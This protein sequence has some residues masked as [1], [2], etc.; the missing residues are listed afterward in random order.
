MYE[1]GFIFLKIAYNGRDWSVTMNRKIIAFLAFALILVVAPV[2][3]YFYFSPKSSD[4][5]NTLRLRNH[6]YGYDDFF[7]DLDSY[8]GEQL[9]FVSNSLIDNTY[10]DTNILG[11]L[12]LENADDNI[13][14]DI[15]HLDTAQD[16]DLT[17]T[18]LKNRLEIETTPAFVFANVKDSKV[19]VID[20]L[21]YYDD[22]PFTKSQLKDWLYENDLWLGPYLD[23]DE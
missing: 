6:D 1:K 14:L 23:L 21:V 18:Q 20:T 16:K 22:E 3:L 10:V 8:Q 12:L 5:V 19:Q 2:Y 17:V 9:I 13:A 7:K 4:D 15:I 11:S